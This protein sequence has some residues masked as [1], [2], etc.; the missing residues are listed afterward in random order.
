MSS[1]NTCQVHREEGMAAVHDAFRS[2]TER[3]L[4]VFLED[5]YRLL[6]EEEEEAAAR[7]ASPRRE[8][9]QPAAGPLVSETLRKLCTLFT[10]CC[11]GEQQKKKNEIL[12][13]ASQ[14]HANVKVVS[15]FIYHY[16]ICIIIIKGDIL[17]HQV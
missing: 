9:L 17:C 8:R 16:F 1:H 3:I 15:G 5:V 4:R 6:L 13:S 10:A 2:Q 14:E 12:N 7:S 11:E